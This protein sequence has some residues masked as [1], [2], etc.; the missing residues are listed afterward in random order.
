MAKAPRP[1]RA[2]IR[3]RRIFGG[4]LDGLTHYIFHQSCW[5]ES[6]YCYLQDLFVREC[7]RGKGIGACLIKQFYEEA[8]LKG[9]DRVYW[10]T[11][12]SNV[13]A[14]QLYDSLAEKS[15]FIQYEKL[16]F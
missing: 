8:A 11:H 13:T 4:K 16:L 5:S 15:G 9:A 1:K 2:H 10:L 3:A 6:P 12:H 14:M 7:T